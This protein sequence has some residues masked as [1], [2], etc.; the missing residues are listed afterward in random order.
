MRNYVLLIEDNEDDIEL[1]CLALQDERSLDD[2][3]VVKRSDEAID[4]LHRQ[5]VYAERSTPDPALILLDLGLPDRSGLDVLDLA[6]RDPELAHIPVTVLT[7]SDRE[8]DLNASYD[9]YAN[10]FLT[11]P[12]RHEDFR[13]AVR[14]ASHFWLHVATSR[15]P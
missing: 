12:V 3:V 2:V 4:F 10:A 11:K 14:A 7:V 1:T 5:G 13:D 15:R 8:A 9:W 6:K